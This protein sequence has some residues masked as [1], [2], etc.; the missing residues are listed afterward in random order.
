MGGL[1]FTIKSIL[2][3]KIGIKMPIEKYV[4]NQ[5]S[6]NDQ[7]THLQSTLGRLHIS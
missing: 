6:S 7:L 4:T 1:D 2:L 3:L 5:R